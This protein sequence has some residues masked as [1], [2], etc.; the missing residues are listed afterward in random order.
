MLSTVLLR[1]D[2]ALKGAPD[3][4]LTLA[5][6]GVAGL[7]LIIAFA[8]NPVEKALALTWTVMP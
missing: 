4:L 8:G 2:R 3:E 7:C 1:A 5:L 6:V